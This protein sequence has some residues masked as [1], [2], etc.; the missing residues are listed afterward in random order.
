MTWLYAVPPY[1]RPRSYPAHEPSPA[2]SVPLR[3]GDRDWHLEPR[4]VDRDKLRD[5]IY[6]GA[7]YR[8]HAFRSRPF[9]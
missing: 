2:R 8:A 3:K 5:G 7:S 1:P 4:L 9:P 6:L